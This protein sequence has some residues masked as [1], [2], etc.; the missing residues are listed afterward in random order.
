M[1]LQIRLFGHLQ[2]VQGSRA[3]T[4]HLRPRAQRLLAY[5]LLHRKHPLPR[6]RVAFTL[7]PDES[8][9][10][11]LALLRR[12]LSELRAV[13]PG[14]EMWIVATREEITWN[15]SAGS[16]IDIDEFDRMI[17]QADPASLSNA[18]DLYTDDLLLNIGDEWALPE[19]ER[20]R[21]MQIDTLRQL[22]AHY[23]AVNDFSTALGFTRR[24][25]ALDPLSES[26]YRDLIA[27]HYLAGDR[28]AAL[29]EFERLQT[30]LEDELGVEPMAETRTLV[31]AI[32]RGEDLHT[33]EITTQMALASPAV[34]IPHKL[35]GRESEYAKLA[36]LWERAAKGQG[37]IAVVSG[38]AGVGKSHLAR[39]LVFHG[40]RRGGLPLVG[41]CFEFEGSLPYQPV[42]EMLRS[43]AHLVQISDLP[44]AY[45]SVLARLLPEVIKAPDSQETVMSPDDLRARLFEAL[46]QTFFFLARRQPLFLVFEDVHWAD[47]STLDWLTYVVP[48]LSDSRLFVLATY[49]TDAVSAQHALARLER[50]FER[51]G[52]LSK[53]PLRPLTRLA[54]RE[55]VTHLSGLEEPVSAPLAD[56]LFIETGGN[57][58]FLQ[59]IVQGLVETGKIT[60]SAGR[61][62][63]AFVEAASVA[64]L[65]LPDSLRETINAR[66]ERLAEM[67]RAFLKTAAVA[68]RVFQFQTVQRAG[69]WDS[70]PALDA[71]E[72]LIARGFLHENE[73]FGTYAFTHHLVKEAIYANL[74]ASRQAYWHRKIAEA[75]QAF[76]PNDFEILAYHFAHAGE[77]ESA[78][79][80]YL[81]A[82]DRA[83]QLV[84]LKDAVE[85]YRAALERWPETDAAGRADTLYK[86]GQC[87]WVSMETQSALES[88]EAARALFEQL[89]ERVKAG[90]TERVVGRLYWELGDR[91]SAIPHHQRALALLEQA[92]ETVEL[93][94]ALSAISQMHLVA[95]EFD[96]AIS[97]G[98]RALALAERLEAEDVIVHALNNIGS[99]RIHMHEFDPERGI[100][101]LRDSLRRALAL[102][103]A[104]D[105]CRAYFNLG[106]DLAGLCRYAEAREAFEELYAYA[107]HVQA[108]LFPGG[109]FRRLAALDWAGGHWAEVLARW[110][111]LLKWSA[112]VWGVWAARL[113]GRIYN[114]LGR[115]E[116]ARLELERTLPRILKWGENQLTVPHLEQLARAYA[117]LGLEAEAG[118][119][120]R[121]FLDLMDRSP[122]LDW[123]C[124]MP[125]LFACSWYAARQ[126]TLEAAR[127]CLPRLE[128]SDHQF[129]IPESQTAL[130]EGRGIVALAEGLPHIAAEH[131]R[132]AAAGWEA[133]DRP[134]DQARALKNLGHALVASGD[135]AVARLAFDDSF[136][137][138]DFL[139]AQ[140]ADPVLKQ[141]FL[142]SQL[143]REVRAACAGLA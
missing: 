111:E 94:R 139:A 85:H 32:S 100:E 27:L 5:L 86:L 17:Q 140:V 62:S 113:I 63:G 118:E 105:A 66:V 96:Q 98:E 70:E 93:A 75:I 37:S 19:R 51:E 24:A 28:A 67:G 2:V 129:R 48:R 102:G 74:T 41:H 97:W 16:W 106:E 91:D 12:A 119:T 33:F 47:Q 110:Q 137:I 53:V 142:N 8:E 103:L 120:V 43:V 46:L 78:R 115:S 87:Q 57:P 42:V 77:D 64:E 40:A 76:R 108:Q 7:W 134:Y 36:E 44:S 131:S 34:Q 104:H 22:S 14:D 133:I 92:P 117:A 132:Q 141:P 58:F 35:V 38:E 109:A 112:G 49:R 101:M 3:L 10:G 18:V 69:G 143:F 11:A 79:G 83:R 26:V 125:M 55:L 135:P 88:F 99:S 31:D 121:H 80:Y 81:R 73:P 116:V 68:G 127:A 138:L 6:I 13:L 123:G 90:D 45:R 65:P 21:Q 82:G 107:R 72:N 114:D 136:T 56:R 4:S 130:T 84:A 50:R 59:E 122:Y 9:E 61:W 124:T 54:Y 1:T 29:A 126:E 52:A 71:L 60:I 89:G 30:L 95:A 25:A 39:S 23:R 128:R 15:P 20:F